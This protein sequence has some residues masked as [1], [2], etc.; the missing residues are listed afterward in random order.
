MNNCF[1]WTGFQ[2]FLVGIEI[3]IDVGI[4]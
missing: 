2:T 3:E 1:L 4:K